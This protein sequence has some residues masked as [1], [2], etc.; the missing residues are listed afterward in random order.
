MAVFSDL[1]VVGFSGSFRFCSCSKHGG[2]PSSSSPNP[3]CALILRAIGCLSGIV[4]DLV[5]CAMASCTCTDTPLPSGFGGILSNLN[6]ARFRQQR[7][8]SENTRQFHSP[9]SSAILC[10]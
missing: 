6:L 4:P 1:F 3:L 8:S 10:E 9:L 7:V 5:Q 2:I